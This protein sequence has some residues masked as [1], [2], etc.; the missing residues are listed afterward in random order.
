MNAGDH[1]QH[2]G[3]YCGQ[4]PRNNSTLMAFYLDQKECFIIP[5]SDLHS[6]IAMLKRQH[7]TSPTYKR[8]CFQSIAALIDNRI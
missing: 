6:E 5:N 2:S 7:D 3:I 1:T 8:S 4:I